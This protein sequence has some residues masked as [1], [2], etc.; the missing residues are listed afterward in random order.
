VGIGPPFGSVRCG[1]GVLRDWVIDQECARRN[2]KAQAQLKPQFWAYWGSFW[3]SHWEQR[4]R[5]DTRRALIV[6]EAWV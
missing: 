1:F 2:M 3:R 6:E 5:L 4:S